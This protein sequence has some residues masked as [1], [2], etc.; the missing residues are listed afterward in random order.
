VTRA[1]AAAVLALALLPASASAAFSPPELFIKLQPWTSHEAVSDWI[2][3]ASAPTVDYLGGYQIGYRLQPSDAEYGRQLVAMTINATPDGTVTQPHAAPPY[4]STQAGAAGTIVDVAPEMQFDGVGTY[5]ITV[6]IGPDGGDEDDC[7]TGPSTT[8]SFTVA[9][10]ATPRVVGTPFSFRSKPAR[11]NPGVEADDPPGGY[12]NVACALGDVGTPTGLVVPADDDDG[13]A[14]RV[15]EDAFTRPGRWSC[16]ARGV[17][18]TQ[19]DAFDTVYAPTP[20]SVPLPV[21]VRSD[22]QRRSG[23]VAHSRARRPTFTFKARWPAESAGGRA[24]LKLYRFAGCAYKK[25]G[26]FRGRFTAGGLKL[27]I[28]RPRIADFYVG[29]LRFGG[30]RLIH[31]SDDPRL[32]DLVVKKRRF[33]FVDPRAIPRCG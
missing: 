26:T 30:T 20:W 22:F 13:P 23:R 19:N 10:G 4:C 6:A 24:R 27:R 15:P 29:V 7:L 11:D 25:A 16:F 14:Q 17:A 18:E 31:K 8:A 21:D 3:L 1:L 5:T 32:V 2:P 33:G 28:R 12:A 9:S